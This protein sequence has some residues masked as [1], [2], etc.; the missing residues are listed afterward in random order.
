VP[1]S[2]C[3]PAGRWSALYRGR[4]ETPETP[5]LGGR[6]TLS[7]QDAGPRQ[8]GGQG[9]P[10]DVVVAFDADM[11]RLGERAPLARLLLAALAWAEGPGLP[12]DNIWIPVALALA[13]DRGPALRWVTGQ[14]VRWLLAAQRAHVAVHTRPGRQAVYRLRDDLVAAHLRGEPGDDEPPSGGTAGTAGDPGT[15]AGWRRRSEARQGCITSALLATVPPGEHGRDWAAAHPYLRS[16][17]ARHA[18]AAGPAVLASLIADDGFL[19]VA[20]PDSVLPVMSLVLPGIRDTIRA[21]RRAAPLLGGDPHANAAYLSEAACALAGPAFGAR[22]GIRPRYRT[23][24]ASARL[25]DSLFALPCPTAMVYSV[26]FGTTPDG[27]LLLASGCDDGTVRLWDPLTGVP[28]GEPLIDDEADSIRGVAPWGLTMKPSET[29]WNTGIEVESVTF[30]IAKDGRLLLASTGSD[31]TVRIWDPLTGMPIGKLTG[32]TGRAWVVAA[33]CAPDG[34]LLLA[35]GS[36]DLT[37][38]VWDAQ[39]LEAIGEPLTGHTD[40]VAGLAIRSTG[41]GR[42]LLASASSDSTVRLWDPLAGAPVGEP[43]TGHDGPAFC[44][45]FGTA[46]DGR[47]LLASGGEDGTVRLWDPLTGMPVGDPMAGH[48]DRVD[49]VSFTTTRDGRFLLVSNGRDQTIRLWDPL[50]GTPVGDP[51][52]GHTGWVFIVAVGADPEGGL[53]LASGS[54]D[55]TIRIW[56]GLAA[57]SRREP[58]SGHIRWVTSVAF[59][60]APDGRRLL[61]AASAMTVRVW[62]LHTSTPAEC[63]IA[64]DMREATSVAFGAIGD[65]LLLATASAGTTIHVWDMLTQELQSRSLHGHRGKLRA[66]EFGIGPDGRPLLATGGADRTVRLWDPLTGIALGV[67]RTG[68]TGGVESLAFCR[69][70][71]GG[72]LLLAAGSDDGTVQLWDPLTGLLASRPLTGPSGRV[73]VLAVAAGRRGRLLLATGG[74]DATVRLWDPFTGRPASKPLAGHSRWIASL[75]FTTTPGGRLLL[76]S[77]SG[78]RTVR[79]WDPA[80]GSCLTTLRRGSVVRSIAAAGLTLAIGGDDGVSVIELDRGELREDPRVRR[81]RKPKARV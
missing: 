17:L 74:D 12:W 22:G 70:A 9:S 66:M 37:V 65:G 3:E 63:P 68:L 50:A 7:G 25:D 28:I 23:A 49:G 41:D 45:A 31:R 18:A 71:P 20:D 40:Q 30:G 59:G 81:R 73:R 53:L 38:R 24:L 61:A 2:A 27:R 6:E 58:V 47:L 4:R 5:A 64:G 19:A 54:A 77:G 36:D 69:A 55:K 15:P 26:A 79:L 39:T 75:A 33:G 52:Y 78:D 32:H 34:R 57:E 46:P 1:T 14:D 13:A 60:A 16:Y 62:D 11:A 29:Y 72:R 35:S 51:L 8:P 21:Y 56:D 44:V 48:T 80:S 67:L 10:A 43:L 42:C 76:A